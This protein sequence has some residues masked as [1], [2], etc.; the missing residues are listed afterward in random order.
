MLREEVLSEEALGELPGFIEGTG[1]LEEAV[2]PVDF[3]FGQ[4]VDRISEDKIS[5]AVLRKFV[6][7]VYGNLRD[8]KILVQILLIRKIYLHLQSQGEFA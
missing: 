3:E 7:T 8:V 6:N 1:F 4:H 2:D 5:A